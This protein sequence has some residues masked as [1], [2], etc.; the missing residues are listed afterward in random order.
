LALT[1]DIGTGDVTT[2][3]CVPADRKATGV[4]I[5]RQPLILAGTEV[6]AELYDDLELNHDD[7]DKLAPNEVI[8]TVA[9]NART[10]LER[11]RIALNFLQRLS[12]V[13]TLSHEFA[14]KVAHTN[15]KILDTRKA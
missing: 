5:A 6:L 4:F 10:L 8:A 3:A 1:E 13:A 15:C 9:G 12:G 7:G 11:E 14:A 2:S